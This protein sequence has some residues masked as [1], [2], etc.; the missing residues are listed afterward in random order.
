MKKNY[1]GRK[2][3]KTQKKKLSVGLCESQAE[4]L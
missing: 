2:F 1:S 3:V 4:C